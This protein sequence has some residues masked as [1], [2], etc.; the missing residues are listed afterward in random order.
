MFP[1][2]CSSPGNLLFTV[3]EPNINLQQPGGAKAG[4]CFVSEGWQGTNLSRFACQFFLK[5]ER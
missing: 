2:G 1:I 4:R 5:F 3:P